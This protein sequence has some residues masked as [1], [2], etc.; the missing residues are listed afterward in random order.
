MDTE[1]EHG[2]LEQLLS[3]YGVATD[4][5]NYAGE[6]VAIPWENRLRV[7]ELLDVD[8][9]TKADAEASLLQIN[10]Q[11]FDTW[12]PRALVINAGQAEQIPVHLDVVDL[13]IQIRW[14][15][16]AEDG[17]RHEG[18]V[19]PLDLAE[20]D[21]HTLAT[22]TISSRSLPLPPLPPGYHQLTLSSIKQRI[23][24]TLIVAPATAYTPDWLARNHK[25]AGLSV[26]VYSLQSGHNW[27]MGDFSDLQ[28]TVLRAAELGLHFLVLNPLHLLD[29]DH[30]ENCSPYSPVDRR[31][32]NPLYIDP[33]QVE[34]YSD[35]PTLQE[36]VAKESIQQELS[37]L[38]QLPQVDYTA[39]TKLKFN[40]FNRMYRHFKK[41][42][43]KAGSPRAEAFHA[44]I[45]AKGEAGQV[46]ARDQASKNRFSFD[47]ARDPLFH[48]YL[49]WLAEIQLEV[50]QQLALGHG[51]AV[52]LVRDLA[53]ASSS[54]SAEVQ[55]NP[56]LFCTRASIGAPPDPLAPQGQNWGLPPMKPTE[57]VDSGY[58]HFITL[59]QNNMAHCGALR[60]D[61]IM[62]LMRL[63]WCPGPGDSSTGAYIYYPV[64]ELFAI[65]RLESLRQQC[66]VIGEDLGVV[67][68]E[69][70]E[71]MAHSSI[72]SNALFYFEK[73]D[74]V[75]FKRPEH[76][77]PRCLAMVANHDVPTLTAWWNK[78]DI[79][80]RREIGL[81]DDDDVL[82]VTIHH[83]E[84]DLIQVL[85]WV[86]NA[87]LL[88]QGWQDFNIHRPF[89]GD[90]C[91][92]I[93]HTSG[94]M[95]SQLVSVQI[96]D[97]CFT[98]LPVNI[99]GTCDEYPNWRRKL[100]LT[101]DELL[102]GEQPRQLLAGLIEGRGQS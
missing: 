30:P 36:Y 27:G 47:N 83:R 44:Y 73:Y 79:A 72:L 2:C 60:I 69:I 1:P 35:N 96:E 9:S 80:L 84:S 55:L 100:P 29:S 7:L 22:H 48:F 101:V 33:R 54:N 52:G 14:S 88:P 70:R 21:T 71:R 42:H 16:V 3:A 17:T 66:V 51:M 8:V 31:F 6:T 38:R 95:A 86:N 67:P 94:R 92:A 91:R 45:A 58:A 43:L 65:L 13:P 28:D 63:W 25:L 46:F 102:A 50:C 82:A 77:A 15:I 89:D 11:C 4:F 40:I 90:L 78:T 37:E 53:V 76:F 26:Q 24:T 39:V 19:A 85:H 98:E 32:L 81:L 75:V 41:E 18:A 56:D 49:Q 93:F 59:L 62:A 87:G 74:G 61:H 34:D 23:Q 5:I 64:A 12:L 20:S 99:P 10:S 57:L 68:P 97:L